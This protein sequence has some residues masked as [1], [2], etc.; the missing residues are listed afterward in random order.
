MGQGV[1]GS[2]RGVVV[3]CDG[4]EACWGREEGG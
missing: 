1:Q 2:R 3:S 4:G